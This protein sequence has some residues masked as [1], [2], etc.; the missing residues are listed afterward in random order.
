[1]CVE[2]LEAS[3]RRHVSSS[4]LSLR[5]SNMLTAQRCFFA[6]SLKIAIM[7][8]CVNQSTLPGFLIFLFSVSWVYSTVV[9]FSFPYIFLLLLSWVYCTVLWTLSLSLPPPESILLSH[10]CLFFFSLES[11]AFSLLPLYPSCQSFLCTVIKCVLFLNHINLLPLSYLKMLQRH[12]CQNV[13]K[14]QVKVGVIF[15]VKHMQNLSFLTP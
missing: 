3:S 1:M 2:P 10:H 13:I 12:F 14:L 11:S 8:K 6:P 4:G 7:F 9:S 15:R 5:F